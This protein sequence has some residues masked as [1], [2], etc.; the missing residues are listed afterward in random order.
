MVTA[1]VWGRF[2]THPVYQPF[3]EQRSTWYQ[4]GWRNSPF[5]LYIIT[6]IARADH[7]QE[8]DLVEVGTIKRQDEDRLYTHMKKNNDLWIRPTRIHIHDYALFFCLVE[9][10]PV[11][12]VLLYSSAAPLASGILIQEQERM[13]SLL[14]ILLCFGALSITLSL[15]SPLP[16]SS[17]G[18]NLRLYRVPATG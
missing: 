10:A 15:V 5:L 6:H 13:D 3:R 2:K 7:L 8:F 9:I 14:V 17:D 18:P 16:G 4:K 11:N 1:S 12:V